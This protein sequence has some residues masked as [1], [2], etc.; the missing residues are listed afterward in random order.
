MCTVVVVVVVVVARAQENANW[1]CDSR[2]VKAGGDPS[3]SRRSI[4]IQNHAYGPC[5]F[6]KR[7]T[8]PLQVLEEEEDS[9][10]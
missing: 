6:S 4:S 9:A 1:R 2:G 3:G 8:L 10:Q 5:D 7:H